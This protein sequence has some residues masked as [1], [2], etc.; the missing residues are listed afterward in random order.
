MYFAD[1]KIWIIYLLFLLFYYLLLFPVCEQL[2]A[3]LKKKRDLP[4]LPGLSTKALKA[5]FYVKDSGRFCRDNKKDDIYTL[6]PLFL[7]WLMK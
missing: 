6:H 7:Q 4:Q 2:V 3:K 5:D 1:G